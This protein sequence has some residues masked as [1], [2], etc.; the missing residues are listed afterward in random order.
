MFW[1]TLSLNSIGSRLKIDWMGLKLKIIDLKI[2]FLMLTR[3]LMLDKVGSL[4]FSLEIT[5]TFVL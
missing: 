5:C 4:G 2:R 1:H 3:W